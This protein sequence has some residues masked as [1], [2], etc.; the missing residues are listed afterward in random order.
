[1]D[2]FVPTKFMSI[3]ESRGVTLDEFYQ[4][5]KGESVLFWNSKKELC[6]KK[7]MLYP[8]KY[9]DICNYIVYY[10]RGLLFVPPAISNGTPKTFSL[11]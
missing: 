3:S 11:F 9:D 6:L 4:V 8:S 5:S 10:F 1:M 2:E 7:V